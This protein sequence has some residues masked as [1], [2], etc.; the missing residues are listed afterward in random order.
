MADVCI[1]ALH[2]AIAPFTGR[3]ETDVSTLF[4]CHPSAPLWELL[5]SCLPKPIQVLLLHQLSLDRLSSVA[6][7]S[8]ISASEE[9]QLGFSNRYYLCSSPA[10]T[11]VQCSA[12]LFASYLGQQPTGLVV[13]MQSPNHTIWCMALSFLT[14]DM[15]LVIVQAL[16]D[17]KIWIFQ[18]RYAAD[19]YMS[20]AVVAIAG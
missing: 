13:P 19:H 7:M 12:L 2:R 8:V 17:A 14:C 10:I 15:S 6:E 18:I 16:R 4:P 3:L 9:S 1:S 20:H 11:A 5:C